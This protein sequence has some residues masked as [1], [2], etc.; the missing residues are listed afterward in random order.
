M[1]PGAAIASTVMNSAGAT[2]HTGAPH[3]DRPFL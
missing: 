3:A 2:P 1:S